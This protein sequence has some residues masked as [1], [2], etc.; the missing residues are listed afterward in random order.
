MRRNFV[1]FIAAVV[2]IL[3]LTGTGFA[4]EK[5]RFGYVNWP[6]VTVKTYVA[7]QLLDC[8]G[9]ETDMKMLSVPVTFRG[10]G[11]NDLD[12]FLGAW[13]P[14]MKSIAEKYL[15]QGSVVPVAV[16]LDET[17]YTL[18]VP[19]YA[20]DAGVKSHA[21]LEKFAD[22]FNRKI[23]GIE[24]GND[25]NKIVLDMIKNNNYD[26][27]KWEIV[28]SSSEAMMITV[29]SS[30]KKKEWIVWLGWS[31]H[32]MNL[33]YDVKYL[34]DPLKIW[35]SEPEIVKTMARAGLKKDIPNVYKL[36]AQFKVTPDIQNEWINKFSREKIKPEEVSEEWIKNNMGIVDQ[37]VYGVTSA[38]GKRAR[39]VIRKAL[40]Q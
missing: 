34:K 23:I 20:W 29:A 33:A 16:N 7:V 8:L 11:N 40:N 31:P 30:M 21:D 19:K 4:G 1:R 18:A 17:I 28:E 26:L 22:K 14:T 12:L 10:L 38:D 3:C 39:D 36:F 15:K 5:I 37:W 25:G 13:L 9:Y 32:W 6:G 27:K 2:C 24:P 35:G